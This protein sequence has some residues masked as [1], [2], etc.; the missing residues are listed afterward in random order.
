MIINLSPYE[1]NRIIPDQLGQTEL[2][3][4]MLAQDYILK[5]LTASLIY[6]EKQLGK[7]FWNT[8]YAKA[9]QEFGT[10]DIPVNTFNKVWIVADK[11]RILERNNVGYVVG[12]KLKV[13][14]EEDYMAL[15]K[16]TAISQV[17]NENKTHKVAS[18][19]VHEIIIPELDKEVNQGK[20]FAPLRQMFYSMILA[21]WYK[22]ALKDA[23]LNQ[24]YSN[25]GKISG[26]LSDDPMVKEKIFEQYLRAYKKGVFNYIRQD[27][28]T[29]SNQPLPRKY[30][31]GGEFLVGVRDHLQREMNLGPGDNAQVV[32][33]M[34]M[35]TVGMTKDQAMQSLVVVTQD[36]LAGDMLSLAE[37]LN[38][39]SDDSYENEVNR[40]ARY[41]EALSRITGESQNRVTMAEIYGFLE[42][43]NQEISRRDELKM[44]DKEGEMSR[45][46]FRQLLE[47]LHSYATSDSV[48]RY[49]LL[50]NKYILQSLKEKSQ[51][52]KFVVI[53]SEGLARHMRRAARYKSDINEYKAV[54]KK[55][56][57]GIA[58]DRLLKQ[59]LASFG[60]QEKVAIA[61]KPGESSR[62]VI[63]DSRHPA[64]EG[65]LYF[66]RGN[67]NQLY[68]QAGQEAKKA[69]EVGKNEIVYTGPFC[70]LVMVRENGFILYGRNNEALT[71]KLIANDFDYIE[72]LIQRILVAFEDSSFADINHLFEKIRNHANLLGQDGQV[73]LRNIQQ[74]FESAKKKYEALKD[75][76]YKFEKALIL[77]NEGDAKVILDRVKPYEKELGDKFLNAQGRYEA[78]FRGKREFKQES[79]K[80]RLKRLLK[81]KQKYYDALKVEGDEG[82]LV[83]NTL[84][85]LK[86]AYHK[87]VMEY[88]PDK[89]PN[90]PEAETRTKKANEANDIIEAYLKMFDEAMQAGQDAAMKTEHALDDYIVSHVRQNY[91]LK[92]TKEREAEAAGSGQTD[93]DRPQKAMGEEVEAAINKR[94]P[95]TLNVLNLGSG[96]GAGGGMDLVKR[97]LRNT[98]V[99]FSGEAINLFRSRVK[100]T[101]PDMGDRNQFE[102]GDM[103]D[104]LRTLK[105]ESFDIVHAHLSL[106]YHSKEKLHQIL[107]EIRRVL[108]PDGKFLF[109]V[110]SMEDTRLVDRNKWRQLEEGE[111]FYEMPKK[112]ITRFF[113]DNFIN[114]LLKDTGFKL[115]AP[116][117]KITVEGWYNRPWVVVA[118]KDFAME[119]I[120]EVV[121]PTLPP[122]GIDLNA[123][124]MSMDVFKEGRGVDMKFDPAIVAEF[125]RGNFSGIV[126]NIIRIVPVKS[127]LS[128]MGLPAATN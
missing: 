43:I 122:G 114:Q 81:P 69:I 65:I 28:D 78:R 126:A 71:I 54:I 66:E 124:N 82:P 34:A 68:F 26:V 83:I 13:M 119:V 16:H 115:Y 106:Q 109:K 18:Q 10:C 50:K 101:A 111:S 17:G 15:K 61:L 63:Y 7:E 92:Y 108:K 79:E 113:T 99:D 87:V 19:V 56:K 3:R 94:N 35:E 77:G 103:L 98:H 27:M 41:L 49:G 39:T 89:N 67:D 11:A 14:L 44:W 95:Q 86:T 121:H 57:F 64:R 107:K 4:D 30:F 36:H 6:P 128:M 59:G 55:M 37:R 91:N 53:L 75:W 40:R 116:L 93:W 45:Y 88:H 60:Y 120:K 52:W 58:S 5:Q 12:A 76:E 97:G 127:P 24:V 51:D 80:E 23:L 2:G 85:Q 38:S 46:D 29:V 125:R 47:L 1:K 62:V 96:D 104:I 102:V 9:Q 84:A 73:Q 31:S 48:M 33:D 100:E 118:Q 105:D 123:K 72:N 22:L 117:K 90:N 110:H 70:P 74:R 20:N 25:K 21:S 32:G 42:R 8:V 112:E